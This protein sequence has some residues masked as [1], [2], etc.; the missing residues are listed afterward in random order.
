MERNWNESRSYSF[1]PS[2]SPPL[3]RCDYFCGARILASRRD[4]QRNERE[5]SKFSLL[6]T[7]RNDDIIKYAKQRHLNASAS[8]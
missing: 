8:T 7:Y 6:R 2:L 1:F 4:S 3:F 5:R